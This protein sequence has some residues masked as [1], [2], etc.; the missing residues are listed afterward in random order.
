MA[1]RISEISAFLREQGCT[2]TE[3]NS[4]NETSTN[5]RYG[6]ADFALVKFTPR[7]ISFPI[8][9]YH[10]NGTV[11]YRRN[12]DDNRIDTVTFQYEND[13]LSQIK[14]QILR[15]KKE[16]EDARDL[17]DAYWK[18]MEV[19]AKKRAVQDAALDWET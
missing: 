4:F 15:A 3:S 11:Y 5:W 14:S 19:N 2:S 6:S 18:R 7:T 17:K 13:S 12:R 16:Y 1:T 9:F 8:G 10:E